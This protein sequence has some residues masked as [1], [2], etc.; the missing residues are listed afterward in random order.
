[1]SDSDA[2]NFPSP[3]VAAAAS[4]PI[5][6]NIPPEVPQSSS[7]LFNL[8]NIASVSFSNPTFGLNE[9][10]KAESEEN[11]HDFCG[12]IKSRKTCPKFSGVDLEIPSMYQLFVSIMIH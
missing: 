12:K 3:P 1:M 5:V 9:N 11:Q 7:G 8:L 2:Q 6:P 4:D 10:W